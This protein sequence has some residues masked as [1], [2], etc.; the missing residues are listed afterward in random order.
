MC[1][2]DAMNERCPT[3]PPER[4]LSWLEALPSGTMLRLPVQI[5]RG[6]FGMANRNATIGVRSGGLEVALDDTAMGIALSDQLPEGAGGVWLRGQWGALV[7]LPM[8][9]GLTLAVR[10]VEG[11]IES[12]D[13]GEVSVMGVA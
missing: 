10:G 4:L 6:P 2:T 13:V 1:N 7:A 11:A 8:S 12:G 3:H 9:S 5:Q